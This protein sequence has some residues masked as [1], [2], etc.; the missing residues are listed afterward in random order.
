MRR[1]ARLAG[2]V[3]FTSGRGRPRSSP[4]PAPR[5]EGSLREDS[6]KSCANRRFS[7]LTSNPRAE[8]RLLPGPW[9]CSGSA[10]DDDRQQ[11]RTECH[12][13]AEQPRA[14]E[15]GRLRAG[16]LRAAR[17]DRRCRRLV[18]EKSRHARDLGRRNQDELRADRL[19]QGEDRHGGFDCPPSRARR[20]PS[21]G[22]VRADCGSSVSRSWRVAGRAIWRRSLAWQ[23]PARDRA[24][25]GARRRR[26][27]ASPGGSRRRPGARDAGE[28][29][30]TSR[31]FRPT[32]PKPVA[33]TSSATPAR[34][35][36]E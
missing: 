9:F 23:G 32:G 35:F 6:G 31:G 1:R 30:R 18:K 21:F 25:S 8:V 14:R 3:A 2:P 20:H 36:K 15:G 5:A 12:E 26:S 34:P 33:S 29:T 16:G 24:S 19:G 17:S 13:Q 7:A 28:R 27:R 4:P 11:E 22:G 10:A